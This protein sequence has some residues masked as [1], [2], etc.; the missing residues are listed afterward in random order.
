MNDD[1]F[2][3]KA[4]RTTRIPLRV[5]VH[6]VVQGEG[7]SRSVDGWTTIVN[8]QGARI[9]CKHRLAI[10]EEVL[11]QIPFNGKAQRGRVVWSGSEANSNGNF[12]FGL[13]LASPENL[14]GVGFP[15]SDWNVNRAITA[16]EPDE[17][18]TGTVFGVVESESNLLSEQAQ[19]PVEI[20]AQN[21]AAEPVGQP[22]VANA[23]TAPV[24]L[25]PSG[26]KSSPPMSEGLPRIVNLT[27]ELSEWETVMNEQ[28]SSGS[29][30]DNGV[31]RSEERRVGK[32]CRL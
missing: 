9:E 7:R 24:N 26:I 22:V 4:R 15:P 1:K 21:Q 28:P 27:A 30:L 19:I 3:L 32:E 25:A 12:E 17:P 29:P 13:E 8:V 16:T 10:D 2:S 18:P 11:L 5:P 6:L 20:A 14:W 23:P 31:L